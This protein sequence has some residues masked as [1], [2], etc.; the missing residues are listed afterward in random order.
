MRR[1]ISLCSAIALIA[2]TVGIVVAG[3]VAASTPIAYS[4]RGIAFSGTVAGTPAGF[5]DT[6][7]LPSTGG[8]Q[9]AEMISVGV[10]GLLGGASLHASTIGQSDRTRTEAS[11]GAVS[12][13][14]GSDS[15]QA[16]FAMSRAMAVSSHGAPV[17]GGSS[18]VS[19]LVV[20]GVA[21]AVTGQVNQ[22]V[23]LP[24]GQL[25]V[26]ERLTSSSGATGSI[27]I[28]AL[29][30]TLADTTDLL[31]SSSRA[32]VTAGSSNCSSGTQPTSGG[33][34]IA[35]P[36]G[37]KGTFGVTGRATASGGFLG[38]VVYTD[39][40]T[41]T[42]I[43]GPVTFY[44]QFG[45][46]SVLEGPAQVNGQPAGNFRVDVQDNGEPGN[47]DSFAISTTGLPPYAAGGRVEGGNIQIHKPC[48]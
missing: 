19:N 18:E 47:S 41:G 2:S 33:G 36:S 17:L 43:R 21:V 25:I 20:N 45:T 12:I 23:P 8:N 16:D 46:N 37:G 24:D 31:V 30:V 38:H 3:P 26:N 39:H 1:R 9:D 28:N 34:W 48:R 13:T 35:T 6:L 15:I 7:S 27:T 44:Q 4:G 14:A 40:A 5:A 10:P 29:H 11:V 42:K 32:G 22:I